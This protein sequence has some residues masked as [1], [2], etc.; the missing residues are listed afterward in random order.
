VNDSIFL[1]FFSLQFLKGEY[2]LH[3]P[4]NHWINGKLKWINCD[5]KY[6]SWHQNRARKYGWQDTYVFTKAMGEM[7]VDNMRGDIP[8]VVIRPSVIEST[9][10]EPFPGWME[11]NR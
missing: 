9:C 3:R 2:K 6:D 8:V 1:F 4:S 10:K 5:L 7:V 11:G